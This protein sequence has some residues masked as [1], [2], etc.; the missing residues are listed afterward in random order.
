MLAGV[1]ETTSE[2]E[3]ARRKQSEEVELGSQHLVQADGGQI[4][5]LQALRLCSHFP[6]AGCLL[7]TTG[8]CPR[9]VT[10]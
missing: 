4:P 8:S 9:R 2:G 10:Q 3:V 6:A 1:R 7:L 5:H